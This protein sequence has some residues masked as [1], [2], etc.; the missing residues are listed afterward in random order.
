MALPEESSGR[1][2]YTSNLNV[3]TK[4][5]DFIKSGGL[6]VTEGRTFQYVVSI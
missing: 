4:V 6:W 1:T 5:L 2:L 3:I